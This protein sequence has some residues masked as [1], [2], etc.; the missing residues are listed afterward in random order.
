MSDQINVVGKN[1]RK[2]ARLSGKMHINTAGKVV[3]AK[4]V[5]ECSCQHGRQKVFRCSEFSEQNQQQL[6]SDYYG[7]SDYSGQC[8]FILNHCVIISTG[9]TGRPKQRHIQFSLP[10]DNGRQRVC[11]K[12]FL[13]TLAVTE[14]L[15]WYT[16][17]KCAADGNQSFSSPDNRGR[18]E[19][20]N[21]T[22]HD[23]LESVC[24]HI[25]SF[26]TMEPH[27][28]RAN[29]SRKFLGSE[30]NI[31]KM[32][33]LYVEECK[34]KDEPFVK[35][36]VYRRVFC[37]EFN[38]SFHRPRKDCC[39]K[40]Q[41][42]ED[43]DDSEKS[44]LK[45]EHERHLQRKELARTEKKS[46]KE[47]AK[48]KNSTWYAMAMSHSRTMPGSCPCTTLLYTIKPVEMDLHGLG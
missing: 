34:S 19:P 40:C 42:F 23:V 8:D 41:Q 44:I 6:L 37:E 5:Q 13:A 46:D 26:P 20:H 25:C 38:F 2:A 1:V 29:T 39:G 33:H 17:D 4:A 9:A 30:L 28:V 16:L 27:Y 12:F 14:S 24:A 7:S 31:Q 10:L 22:S 32:H 21:K 47:K 3:Q 35:E 11:K 18:H 15:V 45:E 48:A 43:A 36:G